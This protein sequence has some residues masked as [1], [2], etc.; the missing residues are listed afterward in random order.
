MAPLNEEIFKKK[1]KSVMPNKTN[2]Q[3]R[4]KLYY[5]QKTSMTMYFHFLL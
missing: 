1:R 5:E 3:A 2:Q 4:K